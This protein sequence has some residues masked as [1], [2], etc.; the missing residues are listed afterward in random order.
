MIKSKFPG[1]QVIGQFVMTGLLILYGFLFYAG[2][3]GKKPVPLFSSLGVLVVFVTVAQSVYI[4]AQMKLNYKTVIIDTD[5]KTISF[6]MFLLPITRTYHL[7]YFDGY[8]NTLVKDKYGKY[9]CFYL[10]KEGKLM[11]KMA[12]RFYSNLDELR[13]GLSCLK[14]LGF[15]KYSFSQ[16]LKIAFGCRI[17]IA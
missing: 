7:D 13:E 6:K 4:I 15:I 9:P 8:I 1:H 2:F 11:Y 5:I 14:D 10:V 16:S 12:G 3:Y 17:G